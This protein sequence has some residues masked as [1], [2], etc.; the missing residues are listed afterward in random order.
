M[1]MQ[2][3]EVHD[4]AKE[5]PMKSKLLM[6]FENQDLWDYEAVMPLMEEEGKAGNEYWTMTARFWLAEL[7]I[8]GLLEVLEEDVDD[9]THFAKDKTIAK[10]RITDYGKQAIDSMLR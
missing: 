7:S 9:G 6:K 8:N 1:M 10:Y 2:Q 5:I 4:M 3:Q